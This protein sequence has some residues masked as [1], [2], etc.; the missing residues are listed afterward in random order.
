LEFGTH[1]PPAFENLGHF[2]LSH[3]ISRLL[4]LDSLFNPLTRRSLTDRDSFKDLGAI[5]SPKYFAYMLTNIE[6]FSVVSLRPR[7]CLRLTSE[8]IISVRSSSDLATGAFADGFLDRVAGTRSPAVERSLQNASNSSLDACTTPHAT[9]APV[10]P[11]VGQHTVDRCAT[12]P[13]H[14]HQIITHN[15]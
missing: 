5:V 7:L 2:L 4:F 1:Y 11:V 8:F 6:P 9:L 3:V 10:V 15:E 13:Q 14:N 12:T